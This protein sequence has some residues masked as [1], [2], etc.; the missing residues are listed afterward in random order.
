MQFSRL[1]PGAHQDQGTGWHGPRPD[2]LLRAHPE[3]GSLQPHCSANCRRL[4]G[5]QASADAAQATLLA[6]QACAAESADPDWPGPLSSAVVWNS[7]PRPA[8]AAIPAAANGAEQIPTGQLAS[9]GIAG[10]S[11]RRTWCAQQTNSRL[12]SSCRPDDA[13]SS[14]QCRLPI[15]SC[16]G[17]IS[18]HPRLGFVLAPGGNWATSL[19]NQFNTAL[20]AFL[21]T[22]LSAHSPR[23]ACRRGVRCRALKGM[24]K[25]N[26]WRAAR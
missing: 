25:T 4:S 5:A 19:N 13:P 23:S 11:P 1:G 9:L 17:L 14:R 15:M 16:K 7:G 10:Q 21:L 26:D 8:V 2:P 20:A 12:V 3:C 6:K 22:V 24:A 18:A